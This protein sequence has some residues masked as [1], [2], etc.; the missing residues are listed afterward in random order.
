M[1]GT[2]AGLELFI[3][4]VM[5]EMGVELRGNSFFKNFGKEGEVRNG[6]EVIEIVG[7]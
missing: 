5:G 6:A 2:D 7:V 4:A 1:E 3:E